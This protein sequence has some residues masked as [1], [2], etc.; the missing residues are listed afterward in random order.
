MRTHPLLRR[1]LIVAVILFVLAAAAVAV[2]QFTVLD[3][4]RPQLEAAVSDTLGMKVELGALGLGFFPDLHLNVTNSRILNRSGGRIASARNLSLAPDLLHLLRGEF[5]L[6]RVRVAEPYV[7]I[8][9]DA[10]GR[11]NIDR[12][13]RFAWL[14]GSLNGARVSLV[15]GGADYLNTASGDSIMLRG[16]RV[17]GGRLRFEGTTPAE[18]LSSLTA[19]AEVTC[20]EVRSKTVTVSDVSTS[21]RGESGVLSL[22]PLSAGL[23]GSRLQGAL[24]ANFTGPVPEW[25]LN[26]SL[27]QF[28]IEDLFAT[29]SPK[30]VATGVL[31]F[32]ARLSM[33]GATREQMTGTMKGDVS[34][35]GK[36]L[37][38]VDTDLDGV[39]SRLE[40][41]RNFSLIDVGVVF[42]A[43]PVGL[44]ATRGY[45]FVGLFRG[46]DGNSPVRVFVSDWTVDGGVARAQDVALATAEN[47]VALK[48][49]IDFGAERYDELTI[50][51]IDK[52]GCAGVRQTIRGT[53]SKPIVDRPALLTSI[54]APVLKLFRET[55]RFFPGGD[56]DPFYTGSV[57][58]SP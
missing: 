13:R 3:R 35:S 51:V 12:F 23:F 11:L 26:A 49:A 8:E 20:E 17:R 6:R 36:S 5:R 18:I 38:L 21:V 7:S 10:V 29:M 37:T 22:D 55:R 52:N 46:T 56:C 39:L 2:I 50:A 54:A 15:D 47:R 43:G 42:L 48:G 41:T 57:A 1:L 45:N 25:Q 31:D 9:R 4:Y 33:R 14:F 40:S 34:L 32:T 44:A 24:H 30:R 58:D 53:F 16:L 28:R 19:G 27:P